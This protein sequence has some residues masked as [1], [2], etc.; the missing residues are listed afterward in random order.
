VVVQK[1]GTAVCS[2]E[3]IVEAFAL[4]QKVLADTKALVMRLKAYRDQGRKIVFTN[5]CFDILHRGHI[6]YLAQAKALGDVLVVAVNSDDSVRRL[7]GQERPV[8]TLEDRMHV[9]AALDSVDLVISFDE[10]TPVE[11]VKLVKPDVYVKGGDYTK[12][13]LPEAPIVEALGGSVVLLP[14]L[15]D[16]STTS[17]IKRIRYRSTGTRR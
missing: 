12:A 6:T 14:Y 5:G 1:N 4:P 15:V 2:A 8:N 17:M 16:R 9:L 13:S 7:K 3:E 11:L 10:N